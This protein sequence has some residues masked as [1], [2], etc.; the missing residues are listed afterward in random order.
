MSRS[1]LLTRRRLLTAA[2][3]VAALRILPA[4]AQTTADPACSMGFVN[5][6]LQYSPDCP[7]LTPPA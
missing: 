4:R 3:G 2:A 1:P 7:L 6:L 5:G